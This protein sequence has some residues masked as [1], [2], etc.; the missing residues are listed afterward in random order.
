MWNVGYSTTVFPARF[1]AIVFAASSSS[2]LAIKDTLL[3]NLYINL[4][5]SRDGTDVQS[6]VRSSFVRLSVR[7]MRFTDRLRKTIQRDLSTIYFGGLGLGLELVQGL[8]LG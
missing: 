4:R 2:Y 5:R 1:T 3:Y 8:R 7:R 6:C